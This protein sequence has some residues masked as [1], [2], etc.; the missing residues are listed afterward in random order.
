VRAVRRRPGPGLA[1]P[2]RGLR[3]ATM[4][5]RAYPRSWRERYGDELLAWVEE[6]GLGPMA[7]LD[8]ARGALDARAHPELV[9]EGLVRM[10]GRLR[11]AV[12]GVLCGYA[13]FVVAGAAYQKLTEYDDFTEAAS[14]HTA[15]GASFQVV[16]VASLVALAAMVAAGA[17]I[18]LA[19]VRQALGGRRE[20]RWPLALVGVSVVWFA[21]ELALL[22]F[23]AHSPRGPNPQMSGSAGFYAWS[24][25]TLLAVVLGVAAAATAVRRAELGLGLL[26]FAAIGSTVV[27]GAMVVML[28]AIMSWGFALRS[29]DPALFN[30]H[31]GIRSGSTAGTWL[32]IVLVMAAA[33]AVAVRSSARGL[34]RDPGATDPA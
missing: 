16:V 29:V 31:E 15:L 24:A 23:E 3:L 20:L 10:V 34:V 5:V 27:A 2:G 7:A 12:L 1:R 22:A 33:S 26:R 19:V 4:L 11:G 30:S 13:A 6:G 8:L 21:S 25:T 9:E 14:R 17:P 32:A 18:G 28:I